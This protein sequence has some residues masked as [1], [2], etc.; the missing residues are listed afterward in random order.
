MWFLVSIVAYT[1]SMIPGS[2]I[3]A[4]NTTSPWLILISVNIL[5]E[6]VT[7][8]YTLQLLIFHLRLI[9]NGYTTRTHTKFNNLK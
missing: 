8:G 7:F 3:S 2:V 5:L 6:S 1:G 9:Y 4:V